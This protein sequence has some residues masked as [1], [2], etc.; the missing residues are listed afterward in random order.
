MILL[1]LLLLS[2]SYADYVREELGEEQKMNVIMK[3]Q[4]KKD[5]KHKAL[6]NSWPS[7]S[8]DH[9]SGTTSARL[10]VCKLISFFIEL[11]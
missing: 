2:F 3:E 9:N 10:K 5:N 8:F 1:C 11:L 6:A 7:S 4:T